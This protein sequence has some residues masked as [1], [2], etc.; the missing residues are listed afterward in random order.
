MIGFTL[1]YFMRAKLSTFEV[2]IDPLVCVHVICIRIVNTGSSLL[3]SLD[4]VLRLSIA[5]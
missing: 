3:S 2:Y 4:V 1:A 5:L